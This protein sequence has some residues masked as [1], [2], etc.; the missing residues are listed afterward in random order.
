[1]KKS[2]VNLLMN[3]SGLFT[4]I[5]GPT[6]TKVTKQTKKEQLHWRH[7][8][9]VELISTPAVKQFVGAYIFQQFEVLHVRKAEAIAKCLCELCIFVDI[10]IAD[11][12]FIPH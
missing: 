8:F 2:S 12:K 6:T 5:E 9:V 3:G 11:M 10:K 7:F 1:M 4:A